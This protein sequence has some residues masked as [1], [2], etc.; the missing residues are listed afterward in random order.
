[1][2]IAFVGE[3]KRLD[4]WIPESALGDEVAVPG[5][6]RLPLKV[7][8]RIDDADARMELLW[9]WAMGEHRLLG[10]IRNGHRQIENMRK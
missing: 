7:C 4:S 2:Y 6:S 9:I 10:T 5:P 8:F 1:M 3:D